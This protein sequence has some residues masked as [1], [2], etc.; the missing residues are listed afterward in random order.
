MLASSS[1]KPQA[2]TLIHCAD[3]SL[4]ET[5]QVG[6][7]IVSRWELCNIDVNVIEQVSLGEIDFEIQ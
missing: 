2:S 1:P 5:V 6:Y 4:V 3:I 7:D